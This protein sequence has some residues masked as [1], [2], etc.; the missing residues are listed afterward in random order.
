MLLTRGHRTSLNRAKYK[1]F[2]FGGHTV[3]IVPTQ[4]CCG[5]HKHTQCIWASLCSNKVLSTKRYVPYLTPQ[6]IVFQIPFLTISVDCLLLRTWA[7]MF[8]RWHLKWHSMIW[9]LNI[10]TNI[11]NP[12]SDHSIHKNHWSLTRL[13]VTRS[14]LNLHHHFNNYRLPNI[15]TIRATHTSE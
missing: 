5:S 2:G 9:W 10:I 13:L 15:I 1:Y 6:A 12:L 7:T 3:S 4:S 11:H 8:V 14:A